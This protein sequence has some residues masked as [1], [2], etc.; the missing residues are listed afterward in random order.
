MSVGHRKKV[1]E[2]I[3][4][5]KKKKKVTERNVRGGR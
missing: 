5:R 4:E 3:G 1:Q 2:R